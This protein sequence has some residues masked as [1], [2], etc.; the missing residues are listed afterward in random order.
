TGGE[1]S[2]NKG[3]LFGGLFSIL[4]LTLLRR[5]KKNNKA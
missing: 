5:N 3:M 1:E 4:G 2:T